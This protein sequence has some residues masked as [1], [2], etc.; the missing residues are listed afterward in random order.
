MISRHAGVRLFGNH[1]QY[2][3]I[4]LNISF[5]NDTSFSGFPCFWSLYGD[6]NRK[7]LAR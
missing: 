4:V 7:I 6:Q 5:F 3:E 1:D 2:R